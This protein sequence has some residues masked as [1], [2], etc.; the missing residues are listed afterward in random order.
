MRRP[1]EFR[2]ILELW[3]FGFNQVEIAEL[4]EVPRE[5]VRDV[6]KRYGSVEGLEKAEAESA[7]A[8]R[9]TEIE[10][11]NKVKPLK[12]PKRT[13]NWR[14]TEDELREAVKNSLSVAQTLEKLGI[15]AAGGNYDTIKKRIRELNID[16]SH[17]TG[18]GWLKNRNNPHTAKLDMAEILVENSTYVSTNGLRGRLIREGYFEHRC[19]SCGLDVWLGQPIP[20]ELD[21]INGSRND[22]RLDNLRLLCPN[23]HALTPTYRGKNKSASAVI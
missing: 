18:K 10:R 17:F 5:T 4:T 19:V 15:V 6:I 22:N 2:K 20:L 23:C 9:Q 21:H 7:E 8:K 1:G 12:G 14:Y 13:G 3:S 16:T 11:Q